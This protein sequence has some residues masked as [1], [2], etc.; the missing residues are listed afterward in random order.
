MDFGYKLS[1]G[2]IEKNVISIHLCE[3]SDSQKVRLGP[4]L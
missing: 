3:I 1:V 2:S 4:K